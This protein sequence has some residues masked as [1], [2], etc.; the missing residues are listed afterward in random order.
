MTIP[1]FILSLLMSIAFPP[2]VASGGTGPPDRAAAVTLAGSR[3][4]V[5]YGGGMIFQG[6]IRTPAEGYSYKSSVDDHDG[7]INQVIVFTVT[8]GD[9]PFVLE[10]TIAGS[11]E[12]FPCEADRRPRGVDVVRH[13]SG[14]SRSLAN[15]AVYDRR[16]DWVLSVDYYASVLITPDSSVRDRHTFQLEAKGREVIVRFRPHFYQKHRALAFFEPWTYRVWREPVVGWCSWFAFF[17]DIT[18]EN[19]RNTADIFAE[20]LRPFGYEYLQIDDGFQSGEGIPELWLKPNGKF[21]SGLENLAGYI[22]GKG[23]KPGIWSNVAFK[24]LD[25]A[26]RHKGWFVLDERGEPARGN[27]IGYSIDGSAAEA[28]DSITRPVYRGFRTMGWRYF[29]VDALRHLRYEGY[30]SFP[31]YFLKKGTD[32][33][34]A[35]RKVAEAV[36]GEI[37]PDVFMLGCWGI[38]PELVGIIDGCRIGTDGFSFAGLSQYNSFNNVVWRNDPDHIELS[39]KEAYRST[40]VTSLTG[41]LFMLTDRPEKYSTPLIEPAR[42]AAPVLFTL[43]GQIFDLDP[44]R[45]DA[46]SRVNSEVSG[47]GPRPFDAGDVPRVHLYSLE[48]DRPYGNHLMLGRTGGTFERISFSDLGLS[49]DREYLVFEFWSKRLLGSFTGEFSPGMID[50]EFNCQLFSIRERL[51]RPQLIA[52]GRHISCGGLELEDLR[53]SDSVLA[54]VSVLVAGDPYDIYLSE[55]EGYILGRVSSDNAD[56]VSSERR[57]GM[58]V[59]RLLSKT[60]GRVSWQVGYTRNGN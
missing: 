56:I 39:E 48:I 53:W 38:R 14:V 58:R 23:I 16:G 59:L 55:P 17:Q 41:S 11:G 5:R 22:A 40:M 19:I 4:T 30:N 7:I 20:K 47:S 29:K 32:R 2:L 44:S 13:V 12:S 52:T 51:S 9:E 31:D 36:R 10:G 15:R 54:G 49:S 60:G 28:L 57:A 42:R 24:D 8:D 46:I 1:R 21:P 25:F 43:P 3:L 35:Y 26:K 37:G 45:S 50:P 6:L 27:W 18:E 33:V 34:G